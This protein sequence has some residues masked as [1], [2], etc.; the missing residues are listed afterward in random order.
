[1]LQAALNATSTSNLAMRMMSDALSV[2]AEEETNELLS[3][4]TQVCVC[5]CLSVSFVNVPIVFA[6]LFAALVCIV[7]VFGCA[8]MMINTV[9]L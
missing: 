7:C 4:L 8:A 2:S 9:H 3:I 1:M 6:C 5:V